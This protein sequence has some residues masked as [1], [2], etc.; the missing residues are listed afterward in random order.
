MKKRWMMM[1]EESKMKVICG[2][3]EINGAP[4][5]RTQAIIESFKTALPCR[6]HVTC[7]AGISL[8]NK[9]LPSAWLNHLKYISVLNE[10]FQSRMRNQTYKLFGKHA[11]T[12][13]VFTPS[14][15]WSCEMT[16]MCVLKLIIT[17]KPY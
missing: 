15:Q 9:T 7:S 11:S 10:K 16:F 13:I 5:L 8:P 14:S 4:C 17:T 12:R 1:S 3:Y 2:S 6:S